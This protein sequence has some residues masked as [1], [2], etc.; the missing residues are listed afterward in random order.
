MQRVIL[1][2]IPEIKKAVDSG[3]RVYSDSTTNAVSKDSKTG[4]YVIRSI[5]NNSIVGLHGKK[6]TDY[7]NN[8]NGMEFFYLED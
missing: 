3:E 6:G 7:E 5:Y 8:L 4:E 2:T 1:R